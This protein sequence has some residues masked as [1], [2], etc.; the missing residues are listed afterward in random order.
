MPETRDHVAF[1]SQQIGPRPAGTEEEQ[2]AALYIT[3]HLQKEAGLSA[4]IEDF[5][6]ASASEAPRALCCFVTILIAALSIYR[7]RELVLPSI[8][9][10][11]FGYWANAAHIFG[12]DWSG[13]VSMSP[14]YS[15]GYSLFLFPLFLLKDP[16]LSYQCGL[17]LNVIFTSS[18]I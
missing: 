14:Y 6:S 5:N 3:E 1:L 13:V 8:L 10:D 11:E 4:V 18:A 17:L 9:N 2:Q 16:S 12:Y 15:Y 7:I